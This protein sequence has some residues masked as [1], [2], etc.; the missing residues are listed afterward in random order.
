M[1]N[2]HVSV[3]LFKSALAAALGVASLTAASSHSASR[4]AQTICPVLA[5]GAF[6]AFVEKRAVARLRR[7]R[8]GD[9]E[10]GLDGIT[11]LPLHSVDPAGRAE[12]RAGVLS[13]ISE[14]DPYGL[15]LIEST[16]V[17]MIATDLSGRILKMN[18]AAKLLTLYGDEDLSDL[19]PMVML[20]DP[21]GM[22]TRFVRQHA[23]PVPAASASLAELAARSPHTCEW[24]YLR[25]DGARICV[26]LSVGP[27][28][29]SDGHIAGYIETAID[30][31][32]NKLLTDAVKQKSF[33]DQLTGLP[34]RL[35]LHDR[36]TQGMKRCD[37]FNEKMAVFMIGIDHFKRINESLGHSGGDTVLQC[38]AAQLKSAV[39]ATDTVVRFA[40]D[41]FA[42]LMPDF[43]SFE[44][45]ARCAQLM[46]EMIA[47]PIMVET[48]QI[49]LSASVGYC[50]YPDAAESAD[51]FLLRADFAMQAAK[52]A[53]RGSCRA[54]SIEMHKEVLGRLEMENELRQALSNGEFAMYYQPQVECETGQVIGME[55]LLRWQSRTRGQVSPADFIPVAE[56]AGLMVA[57]GEWGLRQACKDCMQLQREAGRRFT[58]SVNLSPFQLCQPNLLSVISE[59]LLNSGMPAEDLELEITE[60]VLMTTN[61]PAIETLFALR[62]LGVRVAIDDFGTGYSSFSYILQYQFDR[63]KIDRSFVS[64]VTSEPG[65][66]AIVRTII[67][68]A[69]ALNINVVAEGVETMDQKNFLLR[70][71]CDQVQGFLFSK[72]V[73]VSEFAHVVRRIIVEAN[74]QQR[75]ATK[76]V[77]AGQPGLE[78]FTQDLR[79]VET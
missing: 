65:A 38:V 8:T 45:A 32:E 15:S 70:R 11:T 29:G 36:L 51:E 64:K 23:E 17:S 4:P 78:E 3:S 20:H 77:D 42:V 73:P 26:S 19:Q 54:F 68:M 63:L 14:P 74:K 56:E 61:A 53:D 55:T 22:C 49:V 1:K 59:A 18:S 47:S 13:G 76:V 10:A 75:V 16:A 37:R 31:T 67:A 43:A 12:G 66:A 33:H 52:A 30:L 5:A 57:I 62:Q 58:V 50:L 60:H 25:K 79:C 71:K 35:L 2:L 6:M 40:G 46:R 28:R 34:N 48:R 69:H 44:D 9:L 27:L 21:H 41:V 24:T 39:R 72:A 7:F